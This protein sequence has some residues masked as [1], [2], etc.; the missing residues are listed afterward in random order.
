MNW[1]L[2]PAFCVAAWVLLTL[3]G[4]TVMLVTAYAVSGGRRTGFFTVP[5]VILGDATAMSLS[6]AGLG[7]IMA[8]SAA[9]FTILK[10][11]GAAYLIW[12]GIMMWRR[13]EKPAPDAPLHNRGR[14]MFG[15]AYV[16][17][18]LNPKSIAFFVAFM[19]QF[20]SPEIPAT[21]QLVL[22]G[23]TFLIF[24]GLN[25]ALY[26]LLA[27]SLSGLLRRPRT[28]RATSRIGGCALIGAGLMT[29]AVHRN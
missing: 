9:L 18:A 16:V 3:P 28:H 20:V 15:H 1:E 26:S 14:H 19:P 21:S 5:G 24:A 29:A 17:T 22:L 7:A 12:L 10:W 11:I 8:A 23:L 2:Y 25:A 13:G 27:G 6:L 4:P